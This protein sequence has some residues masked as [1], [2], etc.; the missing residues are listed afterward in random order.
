MKRHDYRTQAAHVPKSDVLKE[1]LPQQRYLD[2][3]QAADEDER[4]AGEKARSSFRG[5]NEI[6]LLLDGKILGIP[7][8]LHY[9]NNL[10]QNLRLIH[11]TV[12]VTPKLSIDFY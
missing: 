3:L 4:G 5:R 9:G 2:R 8:V 12:T 7:V 6:G 11:W 10:I 1:V